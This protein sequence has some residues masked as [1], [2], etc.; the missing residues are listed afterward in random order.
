MKLHC[1]SCG[2]NIDFGNAASILATCSYC[3][4]LVVR[5]DMNL[6]AIGVSGALH[7]EATILQLQTSGT[8]RRGRFMLTGRLQK[9]WAQ[10]Y[11]SEWVASYADGTYA[12][13]SEAQGFFALM[14]PTQPPDVSFD[15]LSVEQTVTLAGKTFVVSDIKTST[16]IAIEGQLP[17]KTG[18]GEIVH[19]VDLQ[20]DAATFASIERDSS[21]NL[22]ACVGKLFEAEELRLEHL[23]HLEG[24]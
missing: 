12:W 14:T 10:G 16:I 4:A 19:S 20:S 13:L 2:A 5:Q 22:S 17:L 24:W 15:L 18:M 23:R 7:Q 3:R 6:E 8:D 11:W 9:Q 1:P 21:G